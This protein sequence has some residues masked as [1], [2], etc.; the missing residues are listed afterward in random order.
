MDEESI[1]K[2]KERRVET[3]SDSYDQI[4]A[5]KVKGYCIDFIEFSI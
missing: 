5:M 1:F 3:T 2:V 4:K